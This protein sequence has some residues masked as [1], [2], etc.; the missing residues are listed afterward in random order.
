MGKL[1][2]G[3]GSNVSVCL[4]LAIAENGLGLHIS[5]TLAALSQTKT[6]PPTHHV[7]QNRSKEN[8]QRRKTHPPKQGLRL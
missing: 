4:S 5:K 1:G 7:S 6:T 3:A 8:S 2:D